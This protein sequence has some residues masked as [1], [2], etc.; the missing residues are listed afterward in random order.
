MLDPNNSTDISVRS[1]VNKG[2]QRN[3]PQSAFASDVRF[4]VRSAIIKETEIEQR[5]NSLI[6]QA[7]TISSARI[8]D[9]F[10]LYNENQ[11]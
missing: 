4:V 11:I 1:I 8:R 2:R 5:K 9:L 6:S 3:P 7:R 10:R